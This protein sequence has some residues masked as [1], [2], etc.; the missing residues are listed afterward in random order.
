MKNHCRV[1][2]L[3]NHL[4]FTVSLSYSLPRSLCHAQPETSTDKYTQSL[5][6]SIKIH[7]IL[8]KYQIHKQTRNLSLTPTE[9]THFCN[10]TAQQYNTQSFSFSFPLHRSLARSLSLAFSLSISGLFM[11]HCI[12]L[13]LHKHT[14]KRTCTRTCTRTRTRACT[15]TR[16]RTYTHM[17]THTRTQHKRY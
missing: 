14:R 8:Q 12:E 13:N 3:Q 10:N 1:F 17:R 16:T 2:T 11:N 5:S 6:L 9:H 15:R 7:A 4:I